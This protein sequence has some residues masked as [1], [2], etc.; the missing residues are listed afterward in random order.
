MSEQIDK[1][2]VNNNGQVSCNKSIVLSIISLATK[3]IT[4]VAS[5]DSRFTSKVKDKFCSNYFEGAKIKF[6]NKKKANIDVYINVYNNFNV[7][8][9]AYKVQENIKSSLKAMINLELGNINVHVI[10]VVFHN[11]NKEEKVD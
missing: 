9:I 8:E 5:M 2:V 10:G 4:G 6:V 11:E 3:E 7:A 1:A